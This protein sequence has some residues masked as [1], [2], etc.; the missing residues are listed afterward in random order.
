MGGWGYYVRSLFSV[1]L[2]LFLN[3]FYRLEFF[4]QFGQNAHVKEVLPP[5]SFVLYLSIIS[6][7]SPS[8]IYLFV[9]CEKRKEEKKNENTKIISKDL[10]VR[11]KM[12]EQ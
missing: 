12:N 5:A 1:F 8:I 10:Q 6:F 4:N 3:S 11:K 7:S 9:F 2:F